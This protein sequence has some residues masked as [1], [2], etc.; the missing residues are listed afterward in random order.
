[1]KTILYIDDDI[2]SLKLFNEQ[3]RLSNNNF[4]IICKSSG[5]EGMDYFFENK[6]NIDLVILD[7]HIPN[8]NGYDMLI[9]IK[10]VDENIPIVMIT[11]S[12]GNGDNK[13]L[14]KKLGASD[15]IIKPLSKKTIS[16]IIDNYL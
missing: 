8:I 2:N 13:D 7:I 16:Y 14:V 11:A 6:N 12:S 15:Y 9:M 3:I 5:E 10:K 4:N 1:M